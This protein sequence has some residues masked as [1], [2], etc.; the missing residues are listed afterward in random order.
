[1]REGAK[2]R[3]EIIGKASSWRQEH[4]GKLIAIH[5][6]SAGEFEASI[7]LIRE[8]KRNNIPVVATLFSPSGFRH[9]EKLGIAD[10]NL[11]LPFDSTSSVRHF[12]S[13]LQPSIFITCKHDIWP[14]LI[15][16]C[17]QRRIPQILINTNLHHRSFRINPLFIGFN[18]AIF[19]LFSQVY[20]ISEDHSQRLRKLLPRKDT[21]EV[22]GDTRFDRV[23]ER[24]MCARLELPADFDTSPVFV[25]GSVWPAENFT[26]DIFL[27]LREHN[28]HW[29][30]IWVPHEPEENFLQWAEKKLSGAD[31]TAIRYSQIQIDGNYQAI[32]VDKMGI[33]A[34]LYRYGNIAYVGGGFGKG[35]HSVLEPAVF[36]IPVIFGPHHYVSSEAGELLTRGGG[37]SIKG[38]E[39]FQ[40]IYRRLS[41]DEVFRL[42]CGKIAG[43]MV[44]EKTGATKI[45]AQ[46]ISQLLQI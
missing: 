12:L 23:E 31:M 27:E 34:G 21:L 4:P 13:V 2:G 25:A 42:K 17:Y 19:G 24:A 32:L 5:S 33:L 15:W 37:F 26:L 18:R 14:N 16:E 44:K 36:G 9:A 40:N 38:A 29:R 11:Y 20:T 43:D 30:L 46:K 1:V 45:I 3:R 28:P 41:K 7:P 8:L 35:V 10:L 6:A 39:E 22:V